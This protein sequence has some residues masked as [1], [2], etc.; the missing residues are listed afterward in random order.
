MPVVV[1]SNH[2]ANGIRQAAWLIKYSVGQSR[3]QDGLLHDHTAHVAAQDGLDTRRCG[4]S[5]PLGDKDMQIDRSEAQIAAYGVFKHD[6]VYLGL[7]SSW[8]NH[9]GQMKKHM[10]CCWGPNG[11]RMPLTVGSINAGSVGKSY[12]QV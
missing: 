5:G 2:R 6:Q 3:E 9:R 4:R 11:T 1:Q 12:F 7:A 8:E 10:F